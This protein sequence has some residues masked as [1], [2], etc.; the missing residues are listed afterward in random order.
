MANSELRSDTKIGLP[1]SS[2]WNE[3]LPFALRMNVPSC[4][5][6]FRFSL[7]ELSLA[8]VR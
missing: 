7:Y 6:V 4:T 5:C 1:P 8:F 3:F 2:G